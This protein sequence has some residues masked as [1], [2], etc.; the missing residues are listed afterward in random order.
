[1]IIYRKILA[2]IKPNCSRGKTFLLRLDSTKFF[3]IF[4]RLD[5]IEN[6]YSYQL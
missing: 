5:K 3:M 6:R 4:A 1:M 2:L